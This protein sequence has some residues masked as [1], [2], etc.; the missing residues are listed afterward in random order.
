MLATPST[1][2]TAHQ[3]GPAYLPPKA[4]PARTIDHLSTP[5]A[6]RKFFCLISRKRSCN[7][8]TSLVR[9]FV[10]WQP[11]RPRKR[12]S[13]SPFVTTPKTV[14]VRTFDQRSTAVL[15]RKFFCPISRKR[16]CNA[17]TSLVRAPVCWQ[18][19]RSPQA[20]F[21]EPLFTRFSRLCL[22]GRLTAEYSPSGDRSF[23]RLRFAI[24]R[25][26]PC[27]RPSWDILASGCR[28]DCPAAQL[29][30]RADGVFCGI[31]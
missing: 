28:C 7:A 31:L 12:P 30:Y 25:G 4:L 23:S 13:G 29:A 16:S 27:G 1:P 20:A 14:P 19:L 15:P 8:R 22:L 10:C 17:R 3:G 2:A 11:L 24:G 9:A 21:K 18:R 5:V 6:P 26:A